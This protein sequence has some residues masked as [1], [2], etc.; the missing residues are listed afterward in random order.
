MIPADLLENGEHLLWQ[1]KPDTRIVWRWKHLAYALCGLWFAGLALLVIYIYT[2]VIP[3]K[4]ASALW[5]YP[6]LLAGLAIMVLSPLKDIY[7]RK[8]TRY[9]LTRTRAIILQDT[10]FLKSLN[11]SWPIT[12]DSEITLTDHKTLPTVFFAK[13]KQQRVRGWH[14]VMI[15]FERISDGQHIYNTM[16]RLQKK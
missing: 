9:F 16:K 7:R 15:G 10:K 14:W 6:L 13:R 2:V 3:E 4:W 5:A 8:H 12:P 1:G 11:Q